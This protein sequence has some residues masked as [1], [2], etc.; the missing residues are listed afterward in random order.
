MKRLLLPFYN[1]NGKFCEYLIRFFYDIYLR[2]STT[3][4]SNSLTPLNDIY[5][6]NST[7]TF[8]EPCRRG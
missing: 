5:L 8:L 2:H 7:L 6:G 1:R 3:P 4:T